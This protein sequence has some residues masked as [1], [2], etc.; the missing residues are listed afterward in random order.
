MIV[1]LSKAKIKKFF[2]HDIIDY[3]YQFILSIEKNDA[4]FLFFS[5]LN[6]F[7]L[8]YDLLISVRQGTI[9]LDDFMKYGLFIIP[10]KKQK[11]N[12]HSKSAIPPINKE[13]YKGFYGD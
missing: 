5:R 13:F 4:K 2:D 8:H 9:D 10:E 6:L 3:W 11:C 12:I 7:F 1:N